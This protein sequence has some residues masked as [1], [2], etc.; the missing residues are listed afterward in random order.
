MDKF[1]QELRFNSKR[2]GPL[3]F[4]A[5]LFYTHEQDK[6]VDAIT[7]LNGETGAPLP[8]PFDNLLTTNTPS[9][10]T[11]YAG[12]ADA[13]WYITPKLD[14][15]AGIRE[16]YNVQ[17]SDATPTGLLEGAASGISVPLRLSAS[18][19]SYLFTIRWRPT[20]NVSA[21]VRAASAYRPGG[22]QF[23]PQPG[24]PSF[25]QPDTVWDYEGGV[26][27]NWFGGRLSADAD[28]YY[29]DWKNI[30]LGALAAGLDFT[31]NGGNAHSDGVEF[32]GQFKPITGLVL[33]LNAAYDHT[34]MDFVNAQTLAANAIGQG[35]GAQVGDPLPLTP[36]WSG[37]LTADYSFPVAGATGTLGATYHYQGSVP[38]SFS[39][40]TAELNTELPAYSV[41]D[42]RA[43]LDW[44]R[45]SIVF[46]VDNLLG[47]Y[48]LANLILYKLVPTVPAFPVVSWG[49]PIQPR[50]FR[51]S[52]EAR[53]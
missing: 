8:A 43:R 34:R 31:G 4:Q 46:R 52:F 7:G 14:A 48:A 40:V 36:K 9:T 1:T 12:F 13:T 6:F 53:F 16:S 39:G 24:V 45:Y 28:I 3:E 30:Q 42:L 33:G 27:G 41:V 37:A 49:F 50:T 18:D 29:L 21:Y 5:G 20:D 44:K 2:F 51:L 10:Y 47:E 19:T 15:T 26:K 22:P 38:T 25:Y 17:T 32:Q 35:S 23:S 11:E